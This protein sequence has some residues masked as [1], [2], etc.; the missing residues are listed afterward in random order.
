MNHEEFKEE[1][2]KQLEEQKRQ[3]EGG[4]QQPYFK[5]ALSRMVFEMA[6]GGA[7]R[8]LAK[9]GYSPE[10]IQK[11]LDYPTSLERIQK[12]MDDMKKACSD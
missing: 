2:R 12:E 9:E 4:D 5:D 7:I 1:Y 3:E 10:E 8:H 11:Q 6:C